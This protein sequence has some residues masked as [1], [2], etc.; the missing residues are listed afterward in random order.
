MSA[1]MMLSSRR[2]KVHLPAT[3]RSNLSAAA[4]GMRRVLARWWK[5]GKRIWSVQGAAAITAGAVLIIVFQVL[6][7][8]Q[9]KLVILPFEVRSDQTTPSDLGGSVAASLSIALN[10][11][12]SLFPSLKPNSERRTVTSRNYSDLIQSFMSDLPFVEVP[13]TSPLNKGAIV[14]E[15]VKIGP[16]SIPISQIVFESLAF[17]HEDTL[18]GSLE[19]WG[20]EIVARVALGREETAITVSVLKDEGY[21]ALINRVTAELLQ[22][23][24]W[25]SPIPMKLSA[26]ILFSEGLRNYLNFDAFAEDK[27]IIGAREKYDAALQLDRNAD[28]ARLHLGATQYVSTDPVIIAK[29][30]ENFSLLV[31]HNHFGRAAKI[32]YVASSLRYIS[33]T[34]GCGGIYRFMAPTLRE[35][36]TWE[37]SGKP[38]TG[39]EELLLW[40][41]TF[42]LAASYLL[43]GKPCGEWIRSI[44]READI[45]KLF[46]KARDGLDQ[47][48]AQIAIPKL[49]SDDEV[50]RYRFYVLLKTKYLLD[51]MVDYA[52]LIKKPDIQVAEAALDLGKEIQRQ[53]EKLPEEQQRFFAESIAGSVAES[54]LRIAKMRESDALATSP[55]VS[56]AI[57]QLRVA[58]G[59]TESLTAHWAL[60]R[61]ADLELS[62]SNAG[63]SLGWL[64]KAYSSLS[65]FPFPFDE[66][67]FPFGILIEKPAQR[68]E[69]IS[70]LKRGSAEGSIASKLFLVDTLRRQGDFTGASAAA[71]SLRTSMET[72]TKWIGVP[73]HQK[74]SLVETKLKARSRETFNLE[75]LKEQF[76]SLGPENEFL[77]FD[78]FE[79]AQIIKDETLLT[80]L[81][82]A[83]RFQPLSQ[84]EV[85]QAP[86]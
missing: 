37:R 64:L 28:L 46:K 47:A 73:V 70:L 25:I 62:R 85:V 18:R 1:D 3:A 6:V 19:I 56:A 31:G 12:R 20:N 2:R 44:F 76:G 84:F 61:L 71:E 50:T 48:M 41:G 63:P 75:A 80:T 15:G 65:A 17:F 69:A 26:L 39:M 9:G 30:I 7:A 54:Y 27:F 68:C 23:K 35:V 78:I 11:Y 55:L 42:Q 21:R 43:P 52:I 74:L 38:P 29:A 66:A 16:V 59:S 36:T 57:D 8:V 4:K 14:L 53:K 81:K 51:D 22:K 13:R 33:R 24:K 58:V 10:E 83:I 77:K 49:Y 67:Y 79:L 60:F 86:C 32:G 40:S 45:D 82:G 34:N 72:S 5:A